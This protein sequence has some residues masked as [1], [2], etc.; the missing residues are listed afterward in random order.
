MTCFWGEDQATAV[1][2]RLKQ[3]TGNSTGVRVLT[4]G[5]SGVEPAVIDAPRVTG[6]LVQDP[7]ARGVPDVDIA[8]RAAGGHLPAIW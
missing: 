7:P 2:A 1:R 5:L 6:Q 8:V 4:Y 3:L